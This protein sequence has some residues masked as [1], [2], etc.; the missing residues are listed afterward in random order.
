MRQRILHPTVYMKDKY[1]EIDIYVLPVCLRLWEAGIKT[2]YSC[3]GGA[4]DILGNGKIR[5]TTAYVSVRDKDVKKACS[6]LKDLKPKVDKHPMSKNKQT[7]LR[8]EPTKAAK[9]IPII[10]E[11]SEYKYLIR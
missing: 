7:A 2:F 11:C 4:S 8:F 10:V 1:V 3:Q 5:S 6:V 9:N